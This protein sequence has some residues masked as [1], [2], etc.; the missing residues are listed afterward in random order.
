MNDAALGIP[1]VLTAVKARFGDRARFD[2]EDRRPYEHATFELI[3]PVLGVVTIRSSEE[4]SDLFKFA[5]RGGFSI[6]PVS[7]GKNWGLGSRMSSAASS[8]IADLSSMNQIKEIN[9]EFGFA[10]IQPGVTFRQLA[11]ALQLQAPSLYLSMIGGHP[12]SSVIGNTVERG[13]G[14]GPLGDRTMSVCALEV[15]LPDGRIMSDTGGALSSRLVRDPVGPSPMGLFFQSNLGVVTELTIWLKRRPK[16]FTALM[17]FIEA[18]DNLAPIVDAVKDLTEQG[19]ILPNSASLWNTY[20]FVASH[21][22][23]RPSAAGESMSE[24]ELDRLLPPG[25]RGVRWIFN[26]GVYGASDRIV[27]TLSKELCRT[28]RPILPRLLTLSRTTAA[29]FRRFPQ[30]SSYLW[31]LPTAELARAFVTESV[32][33]GHPT[34]LSVRS[35]YWRKTSRRP[36]EIDPDRDRCGLVWLCH[37][38][39]NRGSDVLASEAI[40]K[41]VM[42]EHGFEPN[43]AYLVTSERAL[44]LFIAIVY[45]RETVHEDSKAEACWRKLHAELIRCGYPAF[46]LG[47]HSMDQYT[48]DPPSVA[49]VQATL[50]RALD[51]E[52]VLAPGRYEVLRKTG[53]TS[54]PVGRN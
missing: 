54:R 12:D 7:G 51:P 43:L 9:S 8:I 19:V 47:L 49:S 36:R 46:R 16:S 28:L 10:V 39:P 29:L 2:V 1:S 15:V 33:L 4:L 17:G 13:D 21:A 31:G 18:S 45:D 40:C 32:F 44:R 6:Y 3:R 34:E 48:A 23:F 24:A 5:S 41:R 25:L 37:T 42:V 52:G 35:L 27:R 26:V 22:Q 53:S 30:L 14:V 50:K 20:K 11:D 38:V